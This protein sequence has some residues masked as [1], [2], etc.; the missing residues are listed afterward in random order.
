MRREVQ[1]VSFNEA[2]LCVSCRA[3]SNVSRDTCPACGDRGTLLSLAR[4]LQPTPE[5]GQ[6]TYILVTEEACQP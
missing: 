3:I 4:V 5:L 6:I 2:V 1:I